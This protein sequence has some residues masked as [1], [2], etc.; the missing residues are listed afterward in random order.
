MVS[1]APSTKHAQITNEPTLIGITSKAVFRIDPR[2][3]EKIVQEQ[4]K[5]HIVKSDFISLTTSD[6]GHIIVGS[7]RGDIRLFDGPGQMAKT[8]LPPLGRSVQSL[9]VSADGRYVL[10]TCQHYLMLFDVMH[11][12]YN[13]H[14]QHQPVLGYYKMF[15]MG[16]KPV[17]NL[18]KIRP[19]QV[20]LMDGGP[21]SFTKATFGTS[22]YN[23]RNIITV[24]KKKK[25]KE[26]RM[27]R[28]DHMSGDHDEIFCRWKNKKPKK[29]RAIDYK[30][31]Q[32]I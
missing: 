18:L 11:Q 20:M 27:D 30:Y 17:P 19:E 23:N 6:L 29:K 5:R 31:I 7:R 13:D 14:H 4:C 9:D 28:S 10:A 3:P 8:T 24:S 26:T 32:N 25:K 1:L 12:D 21:I 22:R 15:G 16:D 2:S